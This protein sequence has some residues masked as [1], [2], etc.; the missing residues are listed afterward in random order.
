M[1]QDIKISLPLYK[2]VYSFIFIILLS[3]IRGISSV[4]EIGSAVD[5]NMAL[6]AIIFCADTYYQEIQGDR[7]EIFS[8]LS[9]KKR[10]HV[11]RRRLLIEYI[12]LIFLSTACYAFFYIQR[13]YLEEGTNEFGL[14]RITITAVAASIVF[15]GVISMTLVNLTKNLWAG[16]GITVFLWLSFSSTASNKLPIPFQIF[17]FA[18]RNLAGGNSEFSWIWGK[19]TAVF[20]ALLF[21]IIQSSVLRKGKR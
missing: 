2:V 12:Y 5:V 18:N 4:G 9:I 15:F 3:L 6:L 17:A 11:I 8:L 21:I 19:V 7:W 10:T 20:L 16:I 13:P 14:Y 1:K